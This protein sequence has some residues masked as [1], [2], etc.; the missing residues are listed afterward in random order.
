MSSVVVL[1]LCLC[2]KVEII[3]FIFN[4]IM[5]VDSYENISLKG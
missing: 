4:E 5:C 1:W 2:V 3:G